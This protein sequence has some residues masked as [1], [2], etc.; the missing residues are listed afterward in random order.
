MDQSSLQLLDQFSLQINSRKAP[1]RYY[2]IVR[3][4]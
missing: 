2:N 4:D 1:F 3:A